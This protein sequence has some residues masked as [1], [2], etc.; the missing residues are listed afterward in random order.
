MYPENISIFTEKTGD[1]VTLVQNDTSMYKV[2]DHGGI[3][4]YLFSD[5]VKCVEIKYCDHT[6]HDAKSVGQYP[7]RFIFDSKSLTFEF[8]FEN[9]STTY[10]L[11][12]SE[13][14]ASG[15]SKKL[16]K[17]EY[18]VPGWIRR[19]SNY[20]FGSKLSLSDLSI[21]TSDNRDGSGAK[22]I[23]VKKSMLSSKK[24][25]SGFFY[26]VTK[27]YLELRYKDNV[28]KSTEYPYRGNPKILLFNTDDNN[29]SVFFDSKFKVSFN[30]LDLSDEETVFKAKRKPTDPDPDSSGE[31]ES[32]SDTNSD[33]ESN[34]E[35]EGETVP[36]AEIVVTPPKTTVTT[37][38]SQPQTVYS[39]TPK[40]ST[41]GPKRSHT[42]SSSVSTESNFNPESK[43]ISKQAKTKAPVITI[44]SEP[45]D[46]KSSTTL[47]IVDIEK[48]HNTN[49]FNYYR[50][51]NFKTYVPKSGY[52]FS[53]VTEGSSVIWESGDVFATFVTTKRK[54]FLVILLQSGDILLFHKNNAEQPWEDITADRFDLKKLKFF[55]ENDTEI[56]S[57]HYTVT[58]VKTIVEFKFE[59]G[60]NCKKIKYG[61]DN[62]WNHMDD[63]EFPSIK[64]FQ[65]GLVSN[66]LYVQNSSNDW[67]KLN[68]KG[69]NTPPE[70]ESDTVTPSE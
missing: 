4:L 1:S 17:I 68:Y 69:Q 35:S 43:A 49:E 62:I 30:Y 64:M 53:K 42:K 31:T 22:R 15:D 54:K 60:V 12:D 63:T 47:A 7:N 58:L 26:P 24:W 44:P 61:D 10:R 29:I 28:F 13:F 55:G 3:F 46:L 2:Y 37:P 41:S 70:T 57:S 25:L 59:D 5:G 66:D 45:T 14:S 65:F 39:P 40:V 48:K 8:D 51:D 16:E 9:K 67:K 33:S 38:E 27:P 11:S 34:S 18:E 6:V 23:N 20:K 50:N 36:V 56:T 32:D 19:Q 21:L 52:G